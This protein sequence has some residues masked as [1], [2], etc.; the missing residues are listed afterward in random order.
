MDTSFVRERIT[1][2]RM[3][4][5]ISEYQMSYDLGHSRGY[6]NNITYLKTLTCISELFTICDYFEITLPEF[7]GGASN[8]KLIKDVNYG[9][10]QLNEKDLHLI[11]TFVER[12][13]QK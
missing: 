5:G 3:A 8:P 10:E 6:I 2:L 4:K 13:L 7:F 12:L 1:Q 11:Q 9:L